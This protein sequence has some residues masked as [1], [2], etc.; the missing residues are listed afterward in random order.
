MTTNL[1]SSFA[2][3]AAGQNA[4]RDSRGA[5]ADGRGHEWSRRDGRSSNG[6]LTF[7]RP[8]A[9]PH[10]QAS[11]PAAQENTVQSSLD[12]TSTSSAVPVPTD[13][14]AARYSKEQLLELYRESY[15]IPAQGNISRLFMEG[16]HPG[17]SQVNG[18]SSRGWGKPQESQ[19]AQ[20]SDVCWNDTA[21]MKPL[22]LQ[23]MSMEEK[24]MFQSDVNSPMKPP[25]QNK[26]GNQA[27]G[28]NGR[29]ASMSQGSGHPYN[30]TSPTSARPGTRR[31]ESVEPSPFSPA[32]A[33]PTGTNRY[34][35]D[36]NS[37]WFSRKGIDIKESEAVDPETETTPKDLSQ[38]R[39]SFG[40]LLR[41][42]TTGSSGGLGSLWQNSQPLSAGASGPG[43]GSFGNFALPTPSSK[44]FNN[45]RGE[46][47][48]A[49]L[50]P[51]DSS[52]NIAAKAN[53]SANP[54]VNR[55]WRSRPRTDT[56]PF[57]DDSMSGSG[58]LGSGRGETPPAS[59]QGAGQGPFE[60]T[61]QGALGDLGL[62]GLQLD[63]QGDAPLS[64]SD[65]NPYRSPPAERGD[66]AEHDESEFERIRA[67]GADPLHGFGTTTSRGYQTNA[68]D[69]SDR[70][71]TSSAGPNRYPTLSSLGGW[72]AP[73]AVSGTPDRERAA[74]GAGAFGNTLFSPVG[75]VPSGGLGG[76]GGVFGAP[77]TGSIGHGRGSKLGSL[78]PPTMQAQMQPQD[79]DALGD[80]DLR[81][82]NPLGAIG[83][84][85]IPGPSRDGENQPR[86]GM[87]DDTFNAASARAIFTSADAQPGL[88]SAAP[89][90]GGQTSA[91][92]SGAQVRQMVMPDR[93]RWVY[94][95]PQG[96]VQGPFTGLE[97]ND[98]YKANF[99]TPDLRVKK[100]EDPDFEPL[101]QLIRR[102]GNSRE[103][104]LVP[105]IGIPHGPPP[106][107]GPF[108][109]SGNSGVIPP[110]SGVF[111]SYGRTLTAEEQNNLE[112]RKQEE[113]FLM[114]QQRE[115]MLRQQA[116]TKF[117]IPGTT[118]AIPGALHH[119]SS[120][121][122]L[123]S[124]PSFGNI[125]SPLAVP[126]TQGAIGQVSAPGPSGLFDSNITHPGVSGAIGS[127]PDIF[128]DEELAHLSTPERQVL[129][130]LHGPTTAPGPFQQSRTGSQD[131]GGAS[132]RGQLPS[133]EQLV[134]DSEGF[135]E[136]LM[137][138]EQFQREK[139]EAAAAGAAASSP[140]SEVPAEL[141]TSPE[142]ALAATP[143]KESG[144]K[145]KHSEEARSTPAKEQPKKAQ[146]IPSASAAAT[147]AASGLPMPFPPPEPLPQESPELTPA[148]PA[149]P[150]PMA[151]WAKELTTDNQ[152]KGPSLKEIQEAEARKAA[153]AEQAAQAARRAALEQEAA[154]LREK[155]RA[156]STILPGLPTS[157]TW[158]QQSP[159]N[160]ASPWAKPAGIKA[161]IGAAAAAAEKKRK[162][163]AEIQREE[164]ARKAKAR[165]TSIQSGTGIA[166]AGKRY[167]DLASKPNPSPMQAAAA[168]AGPPGAGWAT[169]GAGGKVKTPTGPAAQQPRS[170]SVNAVKPVAAAKT[171]AKPT[172]PIGAPKDNATLAMDEF[173]KWLHNTLSR[174]ITGVANIDDFAATL[175]L[176]PL[177]AEMISDAVYANSTTMNGQHF[178]DEFIRRKKLADKGII[179]KQPSGDGSKAGASSGTGGWSEVA[180]KGGHGSS[181]G[182]DQG[183]S[184]AI[185]GAGFKVVP[186]RKKGGKK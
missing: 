162:T 43:M 108:S 72:P 42:S 106:Q 53:E 114:A 136:R 129:A 163:L 130:S 37:P 16:W 158:G 133:T 120:A 33:S 73:G 49:H 29:K 155:E 182:K 38:T 157:S 184:E 145:S 39:P 31:R 1:P 168:L 137:E 183:S 140:E 96:Q 165:E 167:A 132:L 23:E 93:M 147:A 138:F 80:H 124:Q 20:D 103:P 127:N 82:N 17:V 36:E 84:G 22:A 44:P 105:Q 146:S 66:G 159:V 11:Q 134:Q 143:A 173:K 179:E 68:F 78:F 58:L 15:G 166:G 21:D 67:A 141:A 148:Q 25:P 48:L 77:G 186:S 97:M 74:F 161:P 171:I 50:I 27:T 153:K 30:L 81:Q 174:G 85:A 117:Q 109:P 100:I 151:P 52:E 95:D 75:E 144:R 89:F 92:T 40:S 176:L 121:H 5:R 69:G 94:L 34:T 107:S 135:R 18:H 76:L 88:T 110:L 46:S 119:H 139:D 41:T 28:P 160:A 149:Q 125:A 4:N 12:S 8:S 172:A 102:I 156:A 185:M 59:K 150:P 61:V 9:A 118:G 152:H 90:A 62:S 51:K 131:E 169:V 180:K 71:Q 7:R 99:F 111:P 175:I 60:A 115:F 104:F 19:P 56:D 2:S 55:S 128:R 126:G 178:A 122:S 26:D 87:F 64:P 86:Q 113:Q 3:A 170:T 123:Q 154:E 98:W 47:R 83:R 63:E 177:D 181:S 79:H 116:L 6:T 24:E 57:G 142:P 54:D 112:R 35:R 70:S 65:T 13:L 101:G 32:L 10:N 45:A 91:D 14:S 164:E